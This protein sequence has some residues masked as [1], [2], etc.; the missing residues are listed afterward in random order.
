V[1]EYLKEVEGFLVTIQDDTAEVTN[2]T[3][4][5]EVEVAEKQIDEALKQIQSNGILASDQGWMLEPAY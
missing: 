4:H 5:A 3:I 1:G 2:L